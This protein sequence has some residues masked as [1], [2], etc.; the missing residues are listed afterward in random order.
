[1]N[2]NKNISRH[3][4]TRYPTK[5][6][7]WLWISI[8]LTAII[9][10]L[11]PFFLITESIDLKMKIIISFRCFAAFDFLVCILFSVHYVLTPSELLIR[12]PALN[13]RIPL[14]EIYDVFPT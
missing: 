12:Y 10:L 14:I 4:V 5:K 13:R 7:V 8:A 11:T 2:S 3:P 6:D 1:M 9:F